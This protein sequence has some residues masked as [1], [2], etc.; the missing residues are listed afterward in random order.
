MAIAVGC[1]PVANGELLMGA[2]APLVGSIA[3]ADTVF[4]PVFA[5]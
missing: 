5:T 1:V 2:S 4:E 3:Y